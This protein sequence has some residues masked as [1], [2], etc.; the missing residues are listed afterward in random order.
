MGTL[1]ERM[2]S[3]GFFVRLAHSAPEAL[4][5]LQNDDIDVAVINMCD[6]GAEGIQILESKKET[7][8]WAE[9]ITLTGRDHIRLSIEGMKRGVFADLL[10]PFDIEE[11]LAKLKE[12]GA[13]KNAKKGKRWK[14][15]SKRLEDLT[16]SAA[17]AE[18]ADFDSARHIMA[19]AELRKATPNKEGNDEEY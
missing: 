9:F 17:F 2:S 14:A 10:I 1:S 3:S 4:V 13:K 5:V 12:A 18:A 11:L 19:Q 16:V 15:I 6:L 8:T 7:R